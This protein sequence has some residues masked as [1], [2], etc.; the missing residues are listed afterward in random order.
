MTMDQ[1]RVHGSRG[2]ALA[3]TALLAMLVLAATA[4]AQGA[5]PNPSGPTAGAADEPLL[6]EAYVGAVDDDLF[7]GVLVADHPA[8]P[9]RKTLVAYLCDGADV[10][11]W[12]FADATGDSA[13]VEQGGTSVEMS[14]AEAVVHGVLER[15]GASP[16]LFVAGVADDLAGL[17]RAVE[18][19][20][21]RDYVG[22]WIVLNDG[23]QRGAITLDGAVVDHPTLDPSTK[24]AVS[25]VGTF[26]SNCFRDPRTGD[27]ICRYMN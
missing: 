27:R 6:A 2:V 15:P 10:S 13:V 16:Q 20:G 1:K 12:A 25:S 18:T 14:L 8:E 4:Q 3:V 17:Y 23:R 11:T 21:G 7:I 9:D 22:G 19:I 26:G 5:A 24:Q